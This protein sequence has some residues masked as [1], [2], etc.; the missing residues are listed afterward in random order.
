[1]QTNQD[2]SYYLME[3]PEEGAR[4]E[5]KTDTRLTERL[6]RLVGL[7]EGMRALDVGAGTGAVAR[8][9]SRVV[10]A[11]GS[12]V[13]LDRSR[14]R[15]EQGRHLANAPEFSNLSFVS[16]DLEREALSPRGS[17]DF[18]WCRFVFEYLAAPDA[19]LSNLVGAAKPGGKVVVADLDC[20][21]TIHHPIPADLE[22][23]LRR[24]LEAL[25]GQFD[26]HAGRR[27]FS[28]FRR[29]GLEDIRVHLEPYNVY[30]GA[31]SRDALVNWSEKL[32]VIRPR[33]VR[34]FESE[35]AYDRW[36]ARFLEIL[37][38]PDVFSYSILVLAEGLR[39]A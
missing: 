12:V 3:S 10:G 8:V 35:V 22:A 1:M 36:A 38:D 14:E 7:R 19:A 24:V 26:A 28:R 37:R 9:M 39:T 33:A 30:A 32:R 23:G 34:G 17:Y 25:E 15:I 27:L 31:A 18:V 16:A 2:S 4:L 6:L 11:S 21:G 29:A 20:N 13:A 5:M